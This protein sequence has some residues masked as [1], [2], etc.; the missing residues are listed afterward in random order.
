MAMM[1]AKVGNT[2]IRPTIPVQPTTTPISP[3][4][5]I[6]IN[7]SLINFSPYRQTAWLQR[8]ENWLNLP[9]D[10][11]PRKVLGRGTYGIV[12]RWDYNGDNTAMPR[13]IAVKQTG[14]TKAG[15]LMLESKLLRLLTLVGDE[16]IIKLYKGC[17][18]E[19]GS[20]TDRELDPL[21]YS[22]DTFAGPKELDVSK[23]YIE[24]MPGGD[25][26]QW[27]KELEKDKKYV[28]PEEH[29]WRILNCLARAI[30]ILEQGSDNPAVPDA[31]WKRPICHFDIKPENILI[32]ERHSGEETHHLL[33]VFKLADFGLSLFESKDY[34][35]T[36]DTRLEK[37][38]ISSE[39]RGSPNFTSPE[40]WH[41]Q[42]EE[43]YIGRRTNVWAV[44]AVIHRI[45]CKGNINM[46]KWYPRPSESGGISLMTTGESKNLW[47]PTI[48]PYSSKLIETVASCLSQNPSERMTAADLL[49]KTRSVL[50]VYDMGFR[51]P[52][53]DALRLENTPSFNKPP[54]ASFDRFTGTPP[55]VTDVTYAD[56]DSGNFSNRYRPPIAVSSEQPY[57]PLFPDFKEEIRVPES[58]YRFQRL[59]KTPP[60][61]SKNPPPKRRLTLASRQPLA[62]IQEGVASLVYGKR[63]A[64]PVSP[65]VAMKK[66]RTDDFIRSSFEI[67]P[68][69]FKV[70]EVPKFSVEESPFKPKTPSPLGKIQPL[71]LS[72]K[73]FEERLS[74]GFKRP[75]P[76][77][78]PASF[79]P[80]D[81]SMA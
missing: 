54:N 27:L 71:L 65:D 4:E 12:G 1:T 67:D 62:P 59:P 45:I 23:I 15:P 32:G 47:N 39:W 5:N 66:Q 28:V 40:Q 21:P 63:R 48:C 53:P 31:D 81:E 60:P 2:T 7:D 18:L 77:Q 11:F 75:S 70:V 3:Y 24:F 25:A 17:H 73:S 22:P 80:S 34:N 76:G 20:G 56:E 52:N 35:S 30:L 26:R 9:K 8:S 42:H 19:G 36:S 58:K 16:H 33:E 46:N 49:T 14:V 79:H 43:R 69:T 78:T 68:M 6:E 55:K 72:S 41:K 50:E 10:W 61:P 13:S 37:W 29:L 51:I 57:G 38:Q 44:G 74:A 64:P